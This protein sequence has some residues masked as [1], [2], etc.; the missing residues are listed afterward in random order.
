MLALWALG[1]ASPKTAPRGV[2][3][4]LSDPEPR[5]R[6]LAAWALYRIEDAETVPALEQALN[7][8]QDRHLRMSYIRALGAIGERSSPALARLLDSRDQEVRAMVVSA[9][10]GRGGGPWPWPWPNPR[11]SP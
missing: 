7:R 3:N 11:P 1:N 2:V 4:A 8:E 6:D 9:L 5:V 10:A